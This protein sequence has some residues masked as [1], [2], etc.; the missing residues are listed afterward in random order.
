VGLDNGPPNSLCQRHRSQRD[1][2]HGLTAPRIDSSVKD[3]PQLD[4]ETAIGRLPVSQL[5]VAEIF[6]YRIATIG[7]PDGEQ[8]LLA[9]GQ[10]DLD[11][12]LIVCLAVE[13]QE[14]CECLPVTAQETRGNRAR[15]VRAVAFGL[16]VNSSSASAPPPIHFSK[17]A[18]AGSCD[19]STLI[20]FSFS[21]RPAARPA[22]VGYFPVR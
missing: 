6:R 2:T 17:T 13:L 16:S 18:S 4:P 22:E 9:V 20:S 11:P 19:R 5:Q 14:L 12:R 10:L 3:Q 21:N 15:R 8:P 1:R 7:V